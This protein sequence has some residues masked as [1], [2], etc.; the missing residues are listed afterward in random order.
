MCVVLRDDNGVAKAAGEEWKFISRLEFGWSR[1]YSTRK[2][3]GLAI[4]S[5]IA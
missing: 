3:E 1:D 2:T 4:R 5:A